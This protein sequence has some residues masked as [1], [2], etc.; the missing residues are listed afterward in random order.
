MRTE[1]SIK[2]SIIGILGQVFNI[3]LNFVSRTIFIFILGANYLGVNG[4][5]TNILS[6]LSLAELGI[7]SAIIYHMYKPLANKDEEKLKSLMHLYAKAYRYIGLVVAIVGLSI[8][9][10]LGVII[11]DKPN[12]E[13]LTIIYLL[14][15]ANSV[16]SYFFAYKTSIITADQKVILFQ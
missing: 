11:K 5:F 6:M 9:P 2:N 8:V 1:N 16:V 13:H 15:L 14:F 12:V 4:L 3:I 10:F 7:G